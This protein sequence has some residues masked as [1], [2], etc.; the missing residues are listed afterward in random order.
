[1]VIKKWLQQYMVAMASLFSVCLLSAQKIDSLALPDILGKM[2]S[3]H[4]I[5]FSYSPALLERK[6]VFQS[7]ASHPLEK[8]L[9]NI[10]ELFWLRFEKVDERYYII[11]EWTGGRPICGYLKD[12]DTGAAIEGASIVN[13]NNL[14]G[15]ISDRNGFFQLTDNGK[16]DTISI[17]FIGYGILII[18][19]HKI[20]DRTCRTYPL[21]PKNVALD[22]VIVQEY[23]GTGMYRGNDGSISINPGNLELLSG[24][25]EPDILQNIQ[26]LPGIESPSETA[27]GLYIRGGT[28]DQNLIL[29]DGIK[30]YNFNHFFGMISAF[31]PYIVKNVQVSR[32]GTRPWYGDRV[33]GVVDMVSDDTVPNKVE[34]QFGVNGIHGDAHLKLPISEKFGLL[35]SARRSFTDLFSSPTFLNFSDKVFQNTSL[36]DADGNFDSGFFEAEG[37][38]HFS[39]F[40]LKTIWDLSDRDKVMVSG[41]L[42]KNDLDYS[43]DILDFENEDV[44]LGEQLAIKNHGASASWTRKWHPNFRST[45]RS[46]YSQYDFSYKNQDPLLEDVIVAQ[47]A[48][49]IREIGVSLHTDWDINDTFILSNGYQFFSNEVSYSLRSSS[50]NG[51]VVINQDGKSPAHTLYNQLSYH[52]PRGLELDIGLRTTHYTSLEDTFVEPRINLGQVLGDYFGLRASAELKNQAV[53]Q[54]LEFTTQEFGLENQ[55]WALADMSGG[56]PLLQSEQL[57]AGFLFHKNG[58]KLDVDAYYRHT[59]GITSFTNGFQSSIDSGFIE[60]RSNTMGIDVLVKKKMKRYTTWLGYTYSDT[61]FQFDEINASEPFRGNNDIRHSLTW[62]HFYRWNDWQ[63]SLGWKYRSGTLFTPALGIAPTADDDVFIQYGRFNSKILPDYHRLDLSVLYDFKLS[64]KNSS[65]TAKLGFSLL[66]LYNRKNVL[67]RDYTILQVLNDQGEPDVAL[68]QI[69][70]YSLALTPNIVFRV[71]F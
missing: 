14:E 13:L 21:E 65:P 67:S 33:S 7:Y 24:L 22:E 6:V 52:G 51:T 29:W 62:S 32:S 18:S 4:N 53:S 1:M 16:N 70:R 43:Y 60:G 55:V 54:V 68:K 36:S 9:Q 50:E 31:N 30:M 46:Y 40:T 20:L 28:P 58:W 11:K 42:T 63:F 8:A 69:N 34:G 59:D 71:R 26:L 56:V 10:E 64:R 15:A 66:N 38:F 35:V 45:A 3:L 5:K 23:L 44:K 27:S 2:E 61:Q 41:L 48:N 47:K 37:D 49:N 39:D 25:S 57:A 12:K 19:M 17:S